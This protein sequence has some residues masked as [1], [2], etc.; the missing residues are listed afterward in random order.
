MK[1][2]ELYK[3][4][5]PEDSIWS[6]WAKPVLFADKTFIDGEPPESKQWQSLN[7]AWTPKPD[8]GTAIV[9]DLPGA[10]AVW[11]GMALSQQG[12]RPV[13]LYNGVRGPSLGGSAL[14]SVDAI[15]YA[16]HSVEDT[17]L[18]LR[19]PAN[20]PP[21]FL[22]DSERLAGG[23]FADPGRFDNRWSTFP[24]D[25]PSANFLLSRG[26][27]SVVLGQTM[28]DNPPPG[29]FLSQIGSAVIGKTAPAGPQND[30]AHVL[31]RWQESGLQI[32]ACSVN[33]QS[34]PEPIQVARPDNFRA[35]WYQA[36]VLA[37]LRR[38]ST[39]GFGAVIPEPSSGGGF[40]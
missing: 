39:G 38:N 23:S 15:I 35:L 29:V 26:I 32:L 1:P 37:G 12:F 13:P 4:W 33:H 17:L 31:L 22:L 36:L 27:R 2:S 19:L 9:L 34:Q 30:L 25:F 7:I 16:L 11:Y 24:Q 6:N 40:G 18:G 8:S 28:S 5:A 10:E 14:V 21:V 20:A 3:L